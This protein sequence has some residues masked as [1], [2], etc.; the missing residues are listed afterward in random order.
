MSLLLITTMAVSL[1]SGCKSG[2]DSG[3][4][5]PTGEVTG[6]SDETRAD[7]TD[8]DSSL[9]RVDIEDN[10]SDDGKGAGEQMHYNALKI[11]ENTTYQTWDG[12]GTSSCWW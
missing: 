3:K 6:I 7:G 11:D 10:T 1:L 2:N 8:N 12:F 5:K 9:D 4:D